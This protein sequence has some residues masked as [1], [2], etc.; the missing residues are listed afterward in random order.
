MTWDEI[1]Q[2][3]HLQDDS[4]VSFSLGH[5]TIEGGPLSNDGNLRQM[6]Q[7]VSPFK[8]LTPCH[9]DDL[10]TESPTPYPVYK[11][12]A[13]SSFCPS[14]YPTYAELND[15]AT[16]PSTVDSTHYFRYSRNCPITESSLGYISPPALSTISHDSRS[17]TYM[18]NLEILRSVPPSGACF[19][20]SKEFTGHCLESSPSS[21]ASTNETEYLGELTMA[22]KL[23]K[24]ASSRA[25]PMLT[26]PSPNM[27]W[28]Q[29][30]SR[31]PQSLYEDA[32]FNEPETDETPSDKPYAKLIWQAMMET[33]QK[34]MT[35]R[36]IYDWF[37]QNT[38]KPNDSGTN[39]WQ[40]SIRH[41][42][43]MNKVLIARVCLAQEFIC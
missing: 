39:G 14:S 43:S 31:S 11:N 35:L 21:N 12:N 27:S 5:A 8:E 33:P 22:P 3:Q 2:E 40:N 23:E 19:G 42:L 15:E 28:P 41:N 26:P 20:Q 29:S 4:D 13:P 38:T 10:L 25:S 7:T 17:N 32:I 6:P 9:P 18:D 30:P 24:S 16:V 37:K 1:C 36:Q 34:R